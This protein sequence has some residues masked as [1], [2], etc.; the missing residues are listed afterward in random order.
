MAK[1]FFYVCAGLCLLALS[2]HLGATTAEGQVGLTVEGPYVH[3]Q[4]TSAAIGHTVYVNGSA[5]PLPVPG[6]GR[7]I[8]TRNNE[9]G[10]YGDVCSV[11]L[12]NGDRYTYSTYDPRLGDVRSW[13]YEG[14]IVEGAA[15]S[16]HKAT[17]GQVKVG[18]H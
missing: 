13:R 17:W 8:L 4:W 2:Y 18:Q 11:V 12:E 16:E 14:N 3:N 5:L 9:T 6:A 1:Q 10:G 7:V 15:T